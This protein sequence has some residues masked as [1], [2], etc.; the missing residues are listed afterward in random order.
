MYLHPEINDIFRKKMIVFTSKPIIQIRY[1]NCCSKKKIGA[2]EI[3]IEGGK[4]EEAF[5]QLTSGHKEVI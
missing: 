3:Q 5:K 1:W 4:L 2:R